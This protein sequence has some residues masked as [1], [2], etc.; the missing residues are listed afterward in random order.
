VWTSSSGIASGGVYGKAAGIARSI[1]TGAGAIIT[2][3]RHSILMWT[4]VGE[5]T[6]ENIVGTGTD[7][8]TN[9]FLPRSLNGTGVPGIAIDTG[10]G[11]EP[12]VSRA[13]S[14]GHNNREWN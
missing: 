1:M 3:F 9:G 6:T 13:I 11:K 7:G 12:G 2:K 4:L 10:K 8:T 14:P 5:D